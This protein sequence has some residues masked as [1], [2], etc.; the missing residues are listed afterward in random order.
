MARMRRRRIGEVLQSR[1]ALRHSEARLRAVADHL[2]VMVCFVDATLHFAYTNAQYAQ[3]YNREPSQL[4]G[5]HLNEVLAPSEHA[6]VQ[7]Y[8]QRALAGEKVIFER[9]YQQLR[10]YR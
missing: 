6:M 9:E 7:P 2:P 8:L 1:E 5:K 3:M 4:K 10:G